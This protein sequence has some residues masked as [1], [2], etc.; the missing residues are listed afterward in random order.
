[1][2][3]VMGRDGAKVVVVPARPVPTLSL[4]YRTQSTY[5]YLEADGSDCRG[6]KGGNCWHEYLSVRC[7]DRGGSQQQQH[8][9]MEVP[10]HGM[11]H[12]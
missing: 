9:R 4:T 3:W 5:L 1:M 7:F 10:K 8:D 12:K 2:A 11:P 6:R